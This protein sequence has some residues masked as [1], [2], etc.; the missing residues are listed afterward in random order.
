M[1]SASS[2]Y[3]DFALALGGGIDYKI[4]RR[5]AL[6]LGQVDY[7]H[8]SVNM[9]TLYDGAFGTAAIEGLATHQRNIR[10]STGILV[11]F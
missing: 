6:R 4:S 9:N 2:S 11:R 1:A 8:T 3:T 10:F 5:F 7:F